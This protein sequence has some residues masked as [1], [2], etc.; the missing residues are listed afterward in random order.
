MDDDDVDDLNDDDDLRP[1]LCFGVHIQGKQEVEKGGGRG[2]EVQHQG[3]HCHF[4]IFL[5]FNQDLFSIFYLH[6]YQHF[7][8]LL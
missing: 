4:V 8:H 2:A 7:Q 1:G 5:I 3:L 6:F